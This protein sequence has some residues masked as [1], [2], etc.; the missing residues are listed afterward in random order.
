MYIFIYLN[1]TSGISIHLQL[2][3]VQSQHLVFFI[4][5]QTAMTRNNQ[6]VFNISLLPISLLTETLEV[7]YTDNVSKELF[8]SRYG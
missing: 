5:L 7:D 2:I 4:F 1:T 3:F 8:D 6:L